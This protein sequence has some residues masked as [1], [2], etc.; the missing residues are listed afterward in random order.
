MPPQKRGRKGAK[1]TKKTGKVADP[2]ETQPET[3]AQDTDVEDS[4]PDPVD[5]D[6]PD[7]PDVQDE[8]DC[9]RSEAGGDS[10]PDAEDIFNEKIAEFFEDHPHFY[11]MT[12]NDYKNK[13]RRNFELKEFAAILGHGWTADKVWRRFVSLRTDYGKL[14]GVIQKAKSG[15][16]AP[17]WTPKQKWKLQRLQ[18]LN[19]FMKRGGGPSGIPEEM[20]KVSISQNQNCIFCTVKYIC[21]KY[22]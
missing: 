9:H 4:E 1:P 5:Q 21:V 10:Q 14:K 17:K 7:V 11:N 18:F 20:G 19:P 12:H 13:Q 22:S 3:Q 16:A 2:P 6:V 8:E 15:S